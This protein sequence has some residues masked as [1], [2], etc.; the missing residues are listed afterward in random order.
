MVK[1]NKLCFPAKQTRICKV[2]YISP[3]ATKVRRSPDLL[4]KGFFLCFLFSFVLRSRAEM[5]RT[6]KVYQTNRIF[7]PNYLMASVHLYQSH[8][9]YL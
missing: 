7:L 6:G 5:F 3:D 2:I 9:S 8:F 4:E 1:Q